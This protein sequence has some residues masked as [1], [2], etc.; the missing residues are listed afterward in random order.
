ML[1]SVFFRFG[2]NLL[3]E[4]Q[5]GEFN[6]PNDWAHVVVNYVNQQSIKGYL[7]GEF[8]VSSAQAGTREFSTGS[9][10]IAVGRLHS[11]LDARYVSAQVDELLFFNKTLSEEEIRLLNSVNT[12]MY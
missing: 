12:M 5:A 10:K 9:R 6:T 11:G 3:D 2:D 7:N 4:R 8:V 1:N